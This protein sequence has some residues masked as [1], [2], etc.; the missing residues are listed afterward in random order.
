MKKV[1]MSA[2]MCIALMA[3]TTAIAQDCPKQKECC[4]AKTECTKTCTKKDCTKKK[5]CPKNKKECKRGEAKKSCCPKD[6]K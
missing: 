2:I 6:K 4:K 5:E 1:I 3:S